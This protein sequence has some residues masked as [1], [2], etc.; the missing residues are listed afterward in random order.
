MNMNGFK[1]FF[2]ISQLSPGDGVA[3]G[4]RRTPSKLSFVISSLSCGNRL[5]VERSVWKV[6][7]ERLVQL[8]PRPERTPIHV[9]ESDEEEQEMEEPEPGLE[10][11]QQPEQGYMAE[12]LENDSSEEF[13]SDIDEDFEYPALS[14]SEATNE[15]GENQGESTTES[16][17]GKEEMKDEERLSIAVLCL[18]FTAYRPILPRTRSQTFQLILSSSRPFIIYSWWTPT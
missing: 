4:Y 8:F 16:T 9:E 2:P 15:T 14:D 7:K 6:I 1:T 12:L 11:E 10:M 18:T 13:G 17:N 5:S 3:N